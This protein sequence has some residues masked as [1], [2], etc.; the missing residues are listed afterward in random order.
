M[1][2]DLYRRCLALL[3]VSA[4]ALRLRY[5]GFAAS[6]GHLLEPVPANDVAVDCANVDA[7]LNA[8]EHTRRLPWSS[9]LTRSAAAVARLRQ[10]GAEATLAI[11]ARTTPEFAAH[12]W[13]VVGK[14]HYGQADPAY[15][16]LQ[17]NRG[18][19]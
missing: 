15:V 18:S 1:T 5:R 4:M 6:C 3:A 7:W 12:A 8:F 2:A 16:P 11:G 17:T 14:R 9:C 19:S 10:A 13:V